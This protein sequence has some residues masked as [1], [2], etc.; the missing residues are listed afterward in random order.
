MAPR[1][2]GARRHRPTPPAPIGA[3][4]E[5]KDISE[6]GEVVGHDLRMVSPPVC[7]FPAAPFSWI[8]GEVTA[9]PTEHTTGAANAVNDRGQV[10]GWRATQPPVD[11][12]QGIETE[13][14]VWHDG[15]VTVAPAAPHGRSTS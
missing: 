15:R 9:L 7:C 2:G 5:A 14:V 11:P 13:T 4:I 8:D 6:G 1:S 3:S 10:L 12:Y